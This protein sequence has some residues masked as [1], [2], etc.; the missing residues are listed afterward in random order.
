MKLLIINGSPKKTASN[1][2]FYMN[3]FITGFSEIKGN[4][5]FVEYIGNASEKRILAIKNNIKFYDNI[6]I[7]FPVY[8]HSMPGNVRRFMESL[9]ISSEEKKLSFFIQQTY[10]NS[11]RSLILIEHLKSFSN[12]IGMQ[13]NG[14]M[15]KG[16][17]PSAGMLKKVNKSFLKR[18]FFKCIEVLDYDLGRHLNYKKVSKDFSMMGRY[19]GLYGVFES[20][21]IE[22]YMI[23]K[24]MTKKTFLIHKFFTENMYFKKILKK[25][26]TYQ[27]RY[28]KPLLKK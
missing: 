16:A 7:A 5:Y 14:T 13:Y 6:L 15:F 17:G 9:D 21:L 4:E 19:Y 27:R 10:V 1:T 23:P 24:Q 18:I 11:E 26:N 2:T 12:H 8:Y 28:D 22:S 25:Y 3:F 20:K